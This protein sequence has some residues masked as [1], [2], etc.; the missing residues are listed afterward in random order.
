MYFCL[1]RKRP[2]HARSPHFLTL[3][4]KRALIDFF[5]YDHLSEKKLRPYEHPEKPLFLEGVCHHSM[6]LTFLSHGWVGGWGGP[7]RILFWGAPSRPPTPYNPHRLQLLPAPFQPPLSKGGGL[8]EF[9]QKSEKIEKMEK[10]FFFE[11]F[12]FHRGRGTIFTARMASP[13]L[14]SGVLRAGAFLVIFR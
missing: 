14:A 9:V 7:Y 13:G 11:I 8:P 5:S 4:D 12:G 1:W 2:C 6:S 3:P 10:S